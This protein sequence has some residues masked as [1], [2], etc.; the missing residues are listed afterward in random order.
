MRSDS[1]PDSRQSWPNWSTLTST[2]M[3]VVNSK[4]SMDDDDDL[5]GATVVGPGLQ[6]CGRRRTAPVCH[7]SPRTAPV[8][9]HQVSPI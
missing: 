1:Y 9:S 8:Y 4:E 5:A 2:F 3:Q 7:L 6:T